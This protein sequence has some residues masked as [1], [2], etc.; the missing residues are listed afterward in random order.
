MNITRSN[1]IETLATVDVEQISVSM[2]GSFASAYQIFAVQNLSP[3]L[4]QGPR[5]NYTDVE[6]NAHLDNVAHMSGFAIF[7]NGGITLQCP[8]VLHKETG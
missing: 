7:K 1:T 6:V 8:L 2:K 5:Q 4:R 3:I